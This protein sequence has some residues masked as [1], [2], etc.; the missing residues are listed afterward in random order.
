MRVVAVWH[1]EREYRK[2]EATFENLQEPVVIEVSETQ[3]V[4][5]TIQ[6]VSVISSLP[7]SSHCAM[8]TCKHM[9]GLKPSNHCHVAKGMKRC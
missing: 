3:Q 8:H 5:A 4:H 6:N 2:T 7:S 1:D 9:L